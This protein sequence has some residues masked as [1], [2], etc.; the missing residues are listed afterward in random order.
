[1]IDKSYK[2]DYEIK[3]NEL[4]LGYIPN[5]N[6]PI[7]ANVDTLITHHTA[8]L[9]ITGSGKTEIAFTLIQK[10]IDLKS[11]VFCVDFTGDY[12]D[13][14]KN[15]N[16]QQLA[17]PSDKAKEL[18]EK[19]LDVETGQYGAGKEIAEL[20]K[21]KSILIPE[22]EK[23][24]KEFIESDKYL[25]IFELSEIANTSATIA[26]TEFYLSQIFAYARQHRN[27]GQKFCIVLEEDHTVIP[28][29][30]TMGVQ[31]KYSK[32]T[33]SKISQIA[34]QGRKYNVGLLVITQRTANVT[35]TVLNQCNSIIVF[36]SYDKTGFDFLENYVG[37]GMISSIPNLK[38]LHSMVVGR[39]FKSGRPLIMEIPRK[40]TSVR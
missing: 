36:N 24:V 39:G 21:F 8:I 30:Q 29:S 5:T 18:N 15:F 19:L 22:I 35:K 40:T 1:M 14:F 34:L 26:I 12:I 9:G 27:S 28:E 38:W 23:M 20:E 16:P 6:F 31:D 3:D 37:P 10:M 2:V 33:I 13:E 17:I 32:A 25:G 11:K 7:I 4:I